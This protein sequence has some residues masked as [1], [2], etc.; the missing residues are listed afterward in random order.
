MSEC[1]RGGW[2]AEGSGRILQCNRCHLLCQLLLERRARCPQGMTYL[3]SGC[4]QF[5]SES[6]HYCLHTPLCPEAIWRTHQKQTHPPATDSSIPRARLFEI[7]SKRTFDLLDLV[8]RL[9]HRLRQ[10]FRTISRW[11]TGWCPSQSCKPQ[12]CTSR[13]HLGSWRHGQPLVT[14]SCLHND[15]AEI[16][17]ALIL[18]T[19][20][21]TILGI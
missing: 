19:L 11:P 2:L 6:C 20:I 15:A 10:P 8:V 13:S 21:R 12:K 16:G 7:A 3:R 17:I 18:A 4:M 1:L 14:Q 5:H 9:L